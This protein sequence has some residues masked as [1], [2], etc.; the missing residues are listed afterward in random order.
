MRRRLTICIAALGMMAVAAEPTI[1]VSAQQRYPWNG[2]VDVNVSFEGNVGETYRV[3]LSAIDRA[4]G[5]NLAVATVWRDGAEGM[6]GNPVDVP[7]PGTHRLVWDA[8]ADLPAGFVADRVVLSAKLLNPIWTFESIPAV[9]PS[10][11]WAPETVYHDVQTVA[12]YGEIEDHAP[13][14]RCLTD[15][16]HLEDTLGANVVFSGASMG[17]RSDYYQTERRGVYHPIVLYTWSDSI[18]RTRFVTLDYETG[19]VAYDN[20][21]PYNDNPKS[22]D[23]RIF[24]LKGDDRLYAVVARAGYHA[25][26]K[27]ANSDI[28]SFLLNN[29][30]SDDETGSAVCS[31]FP[32]GIP[33]TDASKTMVLADLGK[34]SHAGI[35]FCGVAGTDRKQAVV[36]GGGGPKVVTNS[37][38]SCMKNPTGRYVV[39][40][41]D[42]ENY[43]TV[44]HGN[45]D[46]NL[47]QF[48]RLF[49]GHFAQF[50]NE[51]FD[52]GHRYREDWPTGYDSWP[53][54]DKS[55]RNLNWVREPSVAYS[56]GVAMPDGRRI[57]L[58][59]AGRDA[60][61]KVRMWQ[62]GTNVYGHANYPAGH[63]FESWARRDITCLLPNGKFCGVDEELGLV[64]VNPLTGEMYVASD[65]PVFKKGKM[66]CQL[67]PN[68]KVWIIP[69]DCEGREYLAGTNM[70]GKLYEVDFGFTKSFSL[71]SLCSPYLKV[72]EGDPEPSGIKVGLDPNG[73]ELPGI[74]AQ[75]YKGANPVYGTLPTPTWTGHTFSGWSTDGTASGAVTASTAVPRAGIQLK[76]VWTANTY[77][78][79]FNANG[80]SGSMSNE[81]F[82]YDVAKTLTANAFK[83]TGYAFSGWA[84]SATGAKAYNDK[85]SVSNLSSTSG[86]TVNLYAVWTA[87]AYSVKFNA[88]TTG[89]TGSMSNESFSYGTAKALTAN[90][91]K[92][93]GYTF[94]GWATSVTGAKAY[95][96]K[97]TVSNLTATAN[98][99]VDLYGLWTTNRYTVR[100]NKNATDATGTMANQGFPYDYEAGLRAIAF[101]RTGYTFAGWAT[102]A[103]GAKVYD[104]KQKVKNLS[105]TNGAT[106]DLYAVWTPI[107]YSVKFNANGGSGTMSN[108][109]FT[110]GTAKALTAN[111]FTRTGYTFAGWATSATGAKAYNDKQSV[112]NLSSASGATVNLYAVWT[113]NAYSVTLDRQS[114]TGGSAS[115]TATYG[116]AMPSITVPTRTGY[117]FGGYYT[118]ANGGGTQYY[119]AAGASARN[120]DKTAATTL[121]A[122]W[123]ANTY[124]VTL[125]RQNGTGGSASATATYGSAMPAITV[126]TRT[127]Y[128]FGGYYTA[129]NG[130]GTQYYTAAGASARNWDKTAATTLY[131]KW[132]ANT[133]AVT[134][135]RQSGTGGST[136]AT[137]TYGSAMPSITVPT[138][139][140]YAFGGY[141]IEANGG[142]T[143][144]YTAAGASARNWDKTAATTLYA[145]WTGNSYSV[146]FNKNASDATGTMSNESFTYGTAK[147]LTANAFARAGYAFAGWATSASG[148][149]VYNDKQSVNNLTAT[150]G[151][152]VD[153]YAVWTTPLYMV[154]D[155]SSGSSSSTYPVSYLAS[156][157]SGGW[158]DE[159]KTT[160]LVLRRIAAGTFTM[161]SPTGEIGRRYPNETQHKVTLSKAYYIG[162]FEVT[163][164]QWELVMGN[165]PSYFSNA[166]CYNTRPVE[167]ISYNAIRGS[168]SGAGWPGSSNVDSTSFIGRVRARTGMSQFDLPTEAQWEYACRAG[169]TTAVSNGMNLNNE[170]YDS[171]IDS[172][173]WHYK[174]YT[175]A[176]T[177]S[178]TGTT[179]TNPVGVLGANPWGLYDMHGNVWEWCLDWHAT[180]LGTSAVTDPKGASTGTQRV[181]RSGAWECASYNC[182]SAR[183]GFEP[184]SRTKRSDSDSDG[185]FGFRLSC[186]P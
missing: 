52:L 8:A 94:A 152:T 15:E 92:K 42:G 85:Q 168:S 137:A 164:R 9:N 58:G 74:Y 78:V 104:N 49:T 51:S 159:Y 38:Y 36:L 154:I 155:L 7:A 157:P 70:C 14:V 180:D 75:Y 5:T 110:Y 34:D 83:R 89:T 161:G 148:A 21:Y 136:S 4:G 40:M 37:V 105:A 139:T 26:V 127:G 143:Q 65:D 113:A 147:A 158:T 103:T 44:G 165:R 116:S 29:R 140:G 109:S 87:N 84:T 30:W 134:L 1:T 117:A 31:Y 138:R 118:A 132:A 61:G 111:A 130:G 12:S 69:Y 121:Y 43:F 88:N 71:S 128:A 48:H 106:V 28:S 82:T 19:V 55:A 160:K 144:Y 10:D 66:G 151:G 149:K 24:S 182:R 162:V 184:P 98:A 156:A 17:L 47:V 145:K 68:G 178:G 81:S 18:V 91:F 32:K 3:E 181:I 46:T 90:A 41:L 166:S 183:R 179:G 107:T 63:P 186:T 101:A 27:S 175:L 185:H 2:L 73:G 170:E 50:N 135:D 57:F 99:V 97:Q 11:V 80:G 16:W 77:S 23:A 39:P 176:T 93:T 124:A 13:V 123:A 20:A 169:T 141:Y 45:S 114:G 122:K 142:G 102:S 112:S 60:D 172:V 163:Q 76:A 120:W 25:V 108:E 95:N 177:S 22:Y 115:A 133:Y 131:A 79:K 33:F 167:Q 56:K 6:V 153:L 64:V 146:K 62:D 54:A 96:D 173:C 126:P 119:T 86:A 35:F 129:A 150:A 59:G 125:D 53:Q 100:Y 72:A 171:R 67:L 174:D